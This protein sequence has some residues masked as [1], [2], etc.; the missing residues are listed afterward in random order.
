MLL[1][2]KCV[3]HTFCSSAQYKLRDVQHRTHSV[4][5]HQHFIP[6]DLHLKGRDGN[7]GRKRLDVA[8][9]HVKAGAVAR[10]LDLVAK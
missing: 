8:A 9:S 5:I 1:G 6:L 2:M 3:S 7:D 4:Y 10:A